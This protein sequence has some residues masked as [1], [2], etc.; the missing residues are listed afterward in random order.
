MNAKAYR[1]KLRSLPREQWE[2]YL[3]ASLARAR[4]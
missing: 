3:L 4:I 1:S 2:A